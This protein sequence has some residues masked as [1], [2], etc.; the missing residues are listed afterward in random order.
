MASHLYAVSRLYDS[1][2][3]STSEDIT[4][5]EWVAAS[6]EVGSNDNITTRYNGGSD[7]FY[8]AYKSRKS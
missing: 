1:G 6:T 4:F 3:E 8:E 5:K 2:A 7:E